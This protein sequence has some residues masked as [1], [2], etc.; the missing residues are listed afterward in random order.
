M[1]LQPLSISRLGGEHALDDAQHPP[2]LIGVAL[3]GGG[4]LLWVEVLEPAALA[5]V[6][7]LAAHLEVQ[8]LV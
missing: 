5:K 3:D 7:A 1:R 2:D 6:G 4:D 8:P